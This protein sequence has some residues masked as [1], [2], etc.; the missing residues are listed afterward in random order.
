MDD[1]NTIQFHLK[2]IHRFLYLVL[3]TLLA[4]KFLIEIHF[5]DN[6]HHAVNMLLEVTYPEEESA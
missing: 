6:V 5:T 3:K 2:T 1:I 4:H